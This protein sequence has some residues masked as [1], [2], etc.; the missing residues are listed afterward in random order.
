[1]M[2][3]KPSTRDLDAAMDLL[4]ILQEIDGRF[5]GPWPTEGPRTLQELDEGFDCDKTA[6]LQAL[7][8][9]LARLLQRAPGFAGRVI[10]GMCGVICYEKNN[11]LDPA[12]DVL[13]M[14]P[15]VLRGLQLLNA[16]RA[17]FLPRME[18]EARAA[19]SSA[20]EAAATRHLY[21]MSIRLTLPRGVK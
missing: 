12:Q 15:D 9:N 10:F 21:E 17:D 3:A 2:M 14:H 13:A 6:H 18:R 8:N 16:Q 5:G 11:Y 19:V 7:Y 1:M 4:G 20:I